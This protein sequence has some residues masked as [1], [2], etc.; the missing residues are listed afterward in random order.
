MAFPSRNGEGD[1]FDWAGTKGY[2]GGC[3]FASSNDGVRAE[4]AMAMDGPRGSRVKARR[5]GSGR[6]EDESDETKKGQ[7][8]LQAVC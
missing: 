8:S 1:A 2:H 7:G 5:N 6:V 3:G 4:A